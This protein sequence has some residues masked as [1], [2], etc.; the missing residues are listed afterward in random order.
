MANATEIATELHRLGKAGLAK[1]PDMDPSAYIEALQPF[2]VDVLQEA[3]TKYLQGIYAGTS[4]AFYPSAPQIAGYCRR[5]QQA[6]YEAGYA[7]RFDQSVREARAAQA[8]YDKR[9]EANRTPEVRAR[10]AQL[11]E[12]V[13]KGPRHEAQEIDR[14]LR[15]AVA[16][17]KYEM[18]PER[19]A[20]VPDAGTSN[21][22]Q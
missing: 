8:A 17:V 9:I 13:P 11:M 22:G 21:R 2:A 20:Q 3:I 7:T 18:T 15:S 1:S 12:K 6:R 10:I 4:A 5:V 14:K 19:L 16:R